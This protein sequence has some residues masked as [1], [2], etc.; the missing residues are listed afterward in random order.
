MSGK[1]RQSVGRLDEDSPI[2]SK[3]VRSCR[4]LNLKADDTMKQIVQSFSLPVPDSKTSAGL[5]KDTQI[6]MYKPLLSHTSEF[7]ATHSPHYPVVHAADKK[8]QT[9]QLDDGA[10]LV[11]KMKSFWEANTDTS[12]RYAAVSPEALMNNT[13]SKV[14]RPAI[15]SSSVSKG[16]VSLKTQRNQSNVSPKTIP[17]QSTKTLM[18]PL[19][20]KAAPSG[21]SKAPENAPRRNNRDKDGP[22]DSMS[23]FLQSLPADVSLTT[24]RP[25]CFKTS[26]TP[27][28]TMMPPSPAP[29]SHLDG[30]ESMVMPTSTDIHHIY[31]E[32][33]NQIQRVEKRSRMKESRAQKR[34][35][36]L[37]KWNLRLPMPILEVSNSTTD[38]VMPET[39][40]LI[41]DAKIVGAH[42]VVKQADC[43]VEEPKP[44]RITELQSIMLLC[45]GET[46]VFVLER[47]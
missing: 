8:V 10:S 11:A 42:M 36:F 5:L 23:P 37:E 38:G 20:A 9:S 21:L 7:A 32:F 40:N 43:E 33:E 35:I 6:R 13:A 18:I 12:F 39:T 47:A 26:A 4:R 44:L 28:T 14:Q 31:A 16:S 1:C 17:R 22:S 15:E 27:L 29:S 24:V 19:P 30:E 41:K 34:K 3:Y 46:G 45:R 2:P 25:L